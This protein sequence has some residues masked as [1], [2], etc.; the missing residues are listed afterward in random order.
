MLSSTT[1]SFREALANPN[2]RGQWGERMAEDVLRHAG[3]IEHVNYEKQV[4]VE[5]AGI[6]DFTF[7]LPRAMCS[8]WT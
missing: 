2:A 6:P 3:F 5:G 7:L 1:Q 4:V 8:S